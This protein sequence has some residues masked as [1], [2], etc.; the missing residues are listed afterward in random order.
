MTQERIDDYAKWSGDFNPLHVNPVFAAQSPFGGT[1][2]HGM[3]VLGIVG[4]ALTAN[5][6]ERWL[7]G[8]RLRA[9]FREPVRPG[10]VLTIRCEPKGPARE[11]AAQEQGFAIIVTNQRDVTVVDCQGAIFA[12]R[13]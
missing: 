6:G 2:A 13:V 11:A 10:D 7:T 9:R 12:V 3:L 4:G 8:G 1:I 5:Y